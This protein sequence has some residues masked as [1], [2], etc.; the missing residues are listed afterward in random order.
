MNRRASQ[1]FTI[2]ELLVVVGIIALMAAIVLPVFWAVEE[3]GRASNC[4]TNLK[5]I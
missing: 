5:N 4:M 1:A 2:V 3:R